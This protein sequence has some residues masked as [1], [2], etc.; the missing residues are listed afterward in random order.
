MPTEEIAA[1][2][3]QAIERGESLEQAKRSFINAGYSRKEV[4]EAASTLGGVLTEFPQ[5][6]ATYQP[7]IFPPLLPTPFQTPY[8]SLQKPQIKKLPQ[9]Q[10]PEK[11]KKPKKKIIILIITLILLFILLAISIFLK[12]QFLDFINSLF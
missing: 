4:E 9:P 5:P 6:T 2:L 8:P 11:T 10:L 1:G 12:N 7:Q 3:K